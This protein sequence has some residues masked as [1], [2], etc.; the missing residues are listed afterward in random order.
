V[1]A[2]SA[3]RALVLGVIL[4]ATALAPRRADARELGVA[5][6]VRVVV[7]EATNLQL[8]AFWVAIGAGYF[9]EEGTDVDLVVPDAPALAQAAFT[10]GAAPV[11]VLAAPMMLR[12]AS[13]RFPFEVVANLFANDPIDL[14]VPRA[15]A[16]SRGLARERPVGDRLRAMHGLRIGVAP[17]PPARLRALFASQGLDAD[18]DVQM[19]LL[20]GRAQN[21]ALAAGQVDALYAHTPFLERAL[22]DQGAVVVVDQAGGEVPALA[23]RLIHGLA[24]TR[25]F[26]REQ[27]RAVTSMV[28]AIGRAEELVHQDEAAAVDAVLRALPGRDRVDRPHV[29]VL[30]SLYAGAVPASPR[31]TVAALAREIAFSPANGPTPSVDAGSLGAFVDERS[32]R[33]SVAPNRRRAPRLALALATALTIAIALLAVFFDRSRPRS[34]GFR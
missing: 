11:A 26:A 21:A 7:P 28:R 4:A 16:E 5:T 33:E 25:A 23:G 31:P 12:L 9:A 10:N 3:P 29:A 32:G 22:L 18:R 13:E 24:V 14:V 19:V 1:E 20:P 17:G 34:E 8:L 30:V 15:V 2:S 6:T 27:R